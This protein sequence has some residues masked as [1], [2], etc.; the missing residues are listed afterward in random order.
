MTLSIITDGV[1]AAAAHAPDQAAIVF[2]GDELTY[3]QLARH[4]GAL[5]SGV[6]AKRAWRVAVSLSNH[7]VLLE[8][9]FGAVHAGG[10]VV[11]FEP[12]WPQE[13]FDLMVK[14]HAPQ[15]LFA[16][17]EDALIWRNAQDGTR[18]ISSQPTPDMPFLIGFTSGTT[19]TPKAF[20]RTHGTWTASFAASAGEYGI[21]PETRMLVPGPLSH[22]LSLYAAVE[23]LNAGG[24]VFM[25][26]RFDSD[27]MMELACGGQVNTIAAAPTLLDLMLDSHPPRIG[28]HVRAIVTAGAKL[29]PRLRERLTAAFP[30]AAVIEYYGASELSFV[31]IARADEGCPPESVGRA[32]AGVELKVSRDDGA[33][34]AVDEVGT[35]W[36]KSAM[37]SSGYVGETDG[38]GF[39]TQDGWA[40]VGDRGSLDARGFLTLVGREGDMI[41]SGGLNVYPQEVEAVLGAA[42]KVAEVL[43]LGEAD[44]R[45]GQIVTAVIAGE[46]AT[47][48]DLKQHCAEHL[49]PYKHPRRWF[50]IA[51]FAH[52][53]SGKIDRA[54]VLSRLKQ[55]RVQVL[56]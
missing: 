51:A 23:T 44:E 55:G 32:F 3:G 46:G 53:A 31:S 26:G 5:A 22:G 8:I 50:R 42:A 7:P 39:R 30:N 17:V 25:E 27:R 24:T 13:T 2:E 4:I 12:R 21:G 45:W 43:V 28:H 48:A 36:V 15:I 11:L 29:P 52:T 9:F 20:I 34:A 49:P 37:V 35:V 18:A 10:V 56:T 14:A 54:D 1:L 19:G 6:D 38:T 40:T 41:I 16:D 47:L 33:P